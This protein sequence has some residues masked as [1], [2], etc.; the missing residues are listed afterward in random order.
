MGGSGV[1]E[2]V[3]EGLGLGRHGLLDERRGTCH[4]HS[5]K[6]L[7]AV[8]SRRSAHSEQH[9]E[10]STRDDQVAQAWQ[11]GLSGEVGNISA[12]PELQNQVASPV[13]HID[14][15]TPAASA[16]AA[17][18]NAWEHRSGSSAPTVSFTTICC[19]R[20]WWRVWWC[21]AQ[22]CSPTAR[23]AESPHALAACGAHRDRLGLV[24][25]AVLTSAMHS[26]S[27]LASAWF[28]GYVVYRLFKTGP[29]SRR[30]AMSETTPPL[31]S[32]LPEPVVPLSWLIGTWVGVGL[33][34]Y[35]TIEDFRFGQE[36]TFTN[37]GRPF[38]CYSSKSWILDDEG[39]RIRP[40]ATEYGFWRPQPT[41][42]LRSCSFIRPDTL[43]PTSEPTKSPGSPTPRSRAHGVNSRPTSSFAATTRK[44]TTAAFGSTDSL[45]A[46]LVGRTTWLPSVNR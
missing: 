8:R 13:S 11:G 19:I 17:T 36:V 37:D 39:N 46:I 27:S 14:T 23:I 45:K 16:V 25:H 30:P 20:Q 33:G 10:R 6:K 1:D 26:S 24:L 21:H 29:P 38:L 35:P 2:L 15:R 32:E 43:R 3:D 5:R 42:N 40:A 7:S 4:P 18:V 34:T 22:P 9:G 12:F 31:P 44:S 41:I 28:V